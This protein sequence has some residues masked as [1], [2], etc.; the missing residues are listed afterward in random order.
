DVNLHAFE[1]L[2]GGALAYRTTDVSAFLRSYRDYMAQA[3]DPLVVELSMFPE[4]GAIGIWALACWSGSAEDADAAL[5][6][7]RTFAPI[8][9][10]TI[11]RVP[12]ARLFAH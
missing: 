11:Q 4:Q 3:P 6:P 2:N 9:A 10:D 1:A 12:P 5:A 8:T 7:L